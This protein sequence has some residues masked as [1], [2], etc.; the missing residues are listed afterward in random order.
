MTVGEAVALLDL[1]AQRG[2]VAWLADDDP[3]AGARLVVD[4][5]GLDGAASLLVT[6][7]FVAVADELPERL[8]LA[9]GRHGRVVLVPVGF[10]ADGGASWHRTDGS[11]VALP[12]AAFDP[13]EAVPRRVRLPASLRPEEDRGSVPGDDGPARAD[14]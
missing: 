4:V 2:V 13:L 9:H 3:T 11:V 1:L 14:V 6:R 5:S 8:E 7:G 12:A 10:R